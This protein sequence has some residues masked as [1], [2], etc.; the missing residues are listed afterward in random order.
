MSLLREKLRAFA[1]HF[2]ITLFVAALAAG[3]IFF[4]WFPRPLDDMV[5]GTKLFLLVTGCDL[6][7][8]PLI[9]LVIYNS[10]KSKRELITDYTLVGLVQLAALIYGV[11]AVSLARPV[12]VAFVKDRIEVI[13]AHEIADADLAQ[14]RADE[15]RALPTDGPKLIGTH[16]KSE[17]QGDALDAALAGREISMRPKFFVPYSSVKDEVLAKAKPLEELTKRKT[18]ASGPI[19]AALTKLQRDASALRWLPVKHARGF[20][21]ALIDPQSGQPVDYVP[22]DPYD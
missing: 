7:L 4:V 18:S 20:W 8:G 2:T 12:Y 14:A 6:A 5:G 16:V 9:S 15:Y 13:T 21:T 3:L 19:D 22:I 1:I 10:R 17:E 11:Y